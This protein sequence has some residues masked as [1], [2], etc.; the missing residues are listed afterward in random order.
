MPLIIFKRIFMNLFIQSTRLT[1][2]SIQVLVITTLVLI[3]NLAW[4]S[5]H[6]GWNESRRYMAHGICQSNHDD[7]CNGKGVC[8]TG[9]PVT[10]CT[11]GCA[12]EPG[13]W[14]QF[15]YYCAEP[16]SDVC[17]G[18]A[19]AKNY[20]YPDQSCDEY[21]IGWGVHYCFI[22]DG[23]FKACTLGTDPGYCMC[24]TIIG[25]TPGCTPTPPTP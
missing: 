23:A 6:F 8:D 24:G 5:D 7:M 20:A 4:S 25:T 16:P 18:N 10:Q 17:T 3:S 11:S 1:M 22:L 9:G 14:Y 19:I 13:G 2:R 21:C 12:E 15:N